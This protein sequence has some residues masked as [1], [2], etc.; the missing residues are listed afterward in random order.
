MSEV[1][2]R[3]DIDRCVGNFPEIYDVLNVKWHHEATRKYGEGGG[4]IFQV[5]G[6]FGVRIPL[7]FLTL[8]MLR[9]FLWRLMILLVMNAGRTIVYH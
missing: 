5:N 4:G 8:P 9:Y 2:A 1:L 3:S 7:C 6:M